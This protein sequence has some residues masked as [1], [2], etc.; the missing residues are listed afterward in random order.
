MDFQLCNISFSANKL[1]KAARSV[2]AVTDE[3]AIDI[4]AFALCLCL[5]FHFSTVSVE[6][7]IFAVVRIQI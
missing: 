3:I 2:S 7:V 6:H 4:P 5:A 1:Q